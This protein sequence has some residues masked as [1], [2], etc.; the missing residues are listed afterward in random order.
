MRL[1]FVDGTIIYAIGQVTILNF[2]LAFAT[3]LKTYLAMRE[4]P[5]IWK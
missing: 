4:F 1:N 5:I 3:S 2:R